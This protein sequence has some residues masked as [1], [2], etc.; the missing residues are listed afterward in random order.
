MQGSLALDIG[1]RQI[2]VNSDCSGVIETIK[3]S[4][5]SHYGSLVR[6]IQSML[7]SFH[8]VILKFENRYCNRGVHNLA[9]LTSSLEPSCHTYVAGYAARSTHL[10]L[11][12]LK[13]NK[14][15]GPDHP[16][17]RRCVFPPANGR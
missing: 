17:D 9:K 7:P 3:R 6:E 2:E 15:C 13:V 1:A 5:K 8:A 11:W 14:V 10:Y 12:F 16:V 4:T